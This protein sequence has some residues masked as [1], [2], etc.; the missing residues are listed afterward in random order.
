MAKL[1]IRKKITC[2]K[3]DMPLDLSRIFRHAYCKAC[4]A[5]H[6]RNT[7]PKHSELSPVAKMKANARALA[8]RYFRMGKIEKKPCF[9]CGSSHSE[10][11][12]EDYAK[13]LDVNWLCRECHLEYH[14]WRE[15][16]LAE[17]A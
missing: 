13:P 8:N 1:K 17:A 6:M 7:R 14:E 15:R 2:A 10:K 12:H 11:H 9:G 4:H 3:C 16:K 5:E